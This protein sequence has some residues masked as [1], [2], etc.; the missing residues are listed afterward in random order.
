MGRILADDFMLITGAGKTYSKTDLLEE[1]KNGRI[2]YERQEDSQRTVRVWGETAVVTALLWAKGTEDDKPFE[3][4]VWFSDTYVRID[5][6]WRYVLGQ[7]GTR[8][9]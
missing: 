4:H 1:A 3:Y 2:I 9:P 6:K 5:G 7:S 8:L